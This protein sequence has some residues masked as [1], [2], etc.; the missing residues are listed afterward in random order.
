MCRPPLRNYHFSLFLS[1][2]LNKGLMRLQSPVGAARGDMG[3]TPAPQHSS[4]I[5]ALHFLG[6]ASP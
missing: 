2:L 1:K 6:P 5:S 3:V 4:A